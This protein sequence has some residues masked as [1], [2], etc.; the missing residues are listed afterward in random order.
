MRR[1]AA[2][3][4]LAVSLALAAC[5]STPTGPVATP[6]GWTALDQRIWYEES[7]GSRLIPYAWAAALEQP[8]GGG[9]FLDDAYL[10]AFRYLPRTRSDGVRLPVGF[11]LDDRDDR[12][13]SNT[14]LRW[15]AN[16]GSREPW[17]GLNCSAC[18]TAELAF[19]G[20][21]I[22]VDGGPT[23]ADFNGFM[24]A[25]NKAL[26]RTE[27][28]PA[29][30]NRFAARVLGGDDT[31]ANRALLKQAFGQLRFLEAETLKANAA[32][33]EAGYGRLD[34]FGHIFNKVTMAA[35]G[36]RG[37]RNPASAP[38]SYPFLWNIHQLPHVQYNAIAAN[39]PM[40]GLRGA[41]LD[42]GAL[43]RNTG[44][45]IGVF[46]D[47]SIR[48]N[49]GKDGYASSVDVDGLVRL[50]QRL[51]RLLPP[52]WPAALPAI[53]QAL[54]AEGA[55]LYAARCAG[56]HLP[57]ARDDL[58]T[59]L[60]DRIS[61]FNPA[62]NT[63]TP[64]DTNPPGTD[65][66]MACNAY[67]Y[68]SATGAL[69]G[70]PGTFREGEPLGQTAFVSA[71]LKATVGGVLTARKDDI[72]ANTFDSWAF[73][74]RP[75]RIDY[76]QQIRDRRRARAGAETRPSAWLPLAPRV[77]P[78]E[79][80]AQRLQRCMTETGPNAAIL[81][82]KA[83]P[84]TGIWATGPYLHNGSVPTLYELLLPP[85]QR[86]ASF[87]M[88]TREIDPVNVGLSTDPAAPGNDQV[89][90]VRDA[91]GRPIPGNSNLGHDYG[92]AGL[93]ERMRRALVEY[94]KTL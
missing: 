6:Q 34:A 20:Q 32:P 22:R 76:G 24:E 10:A 44:E 86:R 8:E 2:A 9:L 31:P 30:W 19:R 14:Q 28:D 46:A 36:A 78:A 15:R 48:P 77:A 80:D 92:N 21:P 70:I 11:A 72:I 87:A 40:D 1:L 60:Q 52:A 51:H 13:L 41:G 91:A 71:M 49:P 16:Q 82:Y 73:G 83:R 33:I 62:N 35:A 50:E 64:F 74:D 88:G 69:A 81:G 67:T 68:R 66:W 53:D 4:S 29:T 27:D 63:T 94:M 39:K 25:F 12:G 89:F 56:C 42:I 84:L 93:S 58:T 38:V 55:P 65:P 7:Q 23:L 85:A 3:G 61:T 17:L 18:H 47:L 54:A 5:I 37:T 43:A 26:A 59:P 75:P 79:T 57:L 45:V 90:R